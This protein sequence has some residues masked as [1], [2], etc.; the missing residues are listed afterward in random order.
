MKKL[1]YQNF[2]W[3]LLLFCLCLFS[4]CEKYYLFNRTPTL[5]VINQY[6]DG[7][8]TV[9][10]MIARDTLTDNETFLC[11]QKKEY[12]FPPGIFPTHSI[13][14]VVDST[15]FEKKYPE[16]A[17]KYYAKGWSPH[18]LIQVGLNTNHPCVL[19]IRKIE[20]IE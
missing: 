19:L 6:V 3:I 9:V 7:W 13:R 18:R 20:I 8:L 10:N 15:K 14:L 2:F 4:G 5:T 12:F 1:I 16:L 11:G 17:K